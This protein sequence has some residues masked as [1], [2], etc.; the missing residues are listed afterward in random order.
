MCLMTL[1]CRHEL[2]VATNKIHAI[3]TWS[4]DYWR[5]NGKLFDR[6]LQLPFDLAARPDLP[7]P[8]QAKYN[9]RPTS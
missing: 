3:S 4:D 2:L 7:P 9:E 8:N 6:L 5:G 1:N